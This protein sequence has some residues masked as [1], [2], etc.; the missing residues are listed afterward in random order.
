MMIWRQKYNSMIDEKCFY[1][2]NLNEKSNI[3][4]EILSLSISQ[5][6][7]YIAELKSKGISVQGNHNK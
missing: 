6:E 1:A 3:D 7:Q 5:L 2:E 4:D